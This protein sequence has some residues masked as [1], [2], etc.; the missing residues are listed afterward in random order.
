MKEPNRVPFSSYDKHLD[1][2]RE[3]KPSPPAHKTPAERKAARANKN[4]EKRARK[5]Q[6][7]GG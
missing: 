1:L 7:A 6:R 4:A 2:T 5:R 3:R